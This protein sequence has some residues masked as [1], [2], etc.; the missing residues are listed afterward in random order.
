MDA[1]SKDW[2]VDTAADGLVA[3]TEPPPNATFILADIHR[4]LN[5]HLPAEQVPSMI[6]LR[7]HSKSKLLKMKVPG[8]SRRPKYRWGAVKALYEASSSHAAGG[9]GGAYTDDQLTRVLGAVLE[10]LVTHLGELTKQV[11]G[12]PSVQRALMNK[13]DAATSLSQARAAAAEDK[14]VDARRLS[15]LET[16]VTKLTVAVARMTER[17]PAPS[18]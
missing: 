6:T 7:R 12:L 3:S 15:D 11:A 16:A 1:I 8:A 14:L 10:P 17:L 2:P 18:G 13:Y 4:L 5:R 9:A